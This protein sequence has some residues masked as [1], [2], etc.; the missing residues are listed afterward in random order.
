MEDKRK[1]YLIWSIAAAVL[2]LLCA[3]M[4]DLLHASDV[5]SVVGYLSDCFVIPGVVFAG[6]GAISWAGTFGVYD[7]L[8]YGFSMVWNQ[9]VHPKKKFP[10]YADYKA[11]RD[12][13]REWN[14]EMLVVGAVCL[15]FSL[16]CLGLY[17][18]L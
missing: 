5:K 6:A 4:G 9:L 11:A 15:A 8:S 13:K 17:F 7:M 1:S 2:F 10:N 18:I 14:R 3:F 12:E 16:L